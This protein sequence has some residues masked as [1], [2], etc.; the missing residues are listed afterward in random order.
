MAVDLWGAL[1]NGNL[2]VDRSGNWPQQQKVVFHNQLQDWAYSINTANT[3]YYTV[4][5]S[6][7][8]ITIGPQSQ[9]KCGA[10]AWLDERVEEMCGVGRSVLA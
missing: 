4:A 1:A 9:P 8:P 7:P 5:A 10:L 3:N 2:G 6:T